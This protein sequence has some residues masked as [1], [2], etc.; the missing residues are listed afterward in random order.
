MCGFIGIV[1]SGGRVAPEIYDGL[2]CLQHRGQ[3]AAGVV[4]FDTRFHLKKGTGLVRDIFNDK[5]M[6]RLT[7]NLGIGHVRYPTIGTGVQEDAQPFLIH[8]PY[9]LAIAHNG[10]VTNYAELA[11]YLSHDK[12]AHL[13]S[14]CDVEVILNVIAVELGR[15][16]VP[17]LTPDVLFQVVGKVFE[18]VK[19]TYSVVLLIAGY[20]LLAFR[21]PHG[22]KPMIYGRRGNG[23]GDIEYAV[24]SENVAIDILGYRQWTDV[25]PGE[26]ILF[27]PGQPPVSKRIVTR[28]H[29]PCIFEHVYF[30]RPDTIMDGISV[31]QSRR[32][33][34]EK[35]AETWR[36]TGIPVDVI[37]PVPDS[38]CTA[39]G[40]MA[41]I[42]GVEYREGLVKNRYIGRTFIM[43]DQSQRSESIRRKLNAIPLEFE[44]KDVLL[45]DDSI[46][47]GN[48]SKKI[49]ELARNAGARRVYFASCSPPIRFPCIYGIDMS[50][51]REL[52]A[53]EKDVEEIARHIGADYLIFQDLPDLED[54]ARAGNPEVTSFCTAC[55]SGNYPTGDVTPEMLSE[56]ERE[57]LGAC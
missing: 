34:G 55:F 31:Y 2:L 4:T 49:I 52:I 26:A 41:N 10:N 51:R 8:Y 23:K 28:T 32:R 16:G 17:E 45:V 39:A 42:L 35:L 46:V 15:M 13:N 33:F 37:I 30:A 47:R 25:K 24:A 18:R 29:S 11:R 53:R 50:T 57:R 44:G 36:Q 21:D 3:D 6:A 7:G 38:A 27:R 22:V 43:P 56:I 5:N 48:T 1:A 54:A 9:G 14:T 19:G 40:T 12:K 20:G